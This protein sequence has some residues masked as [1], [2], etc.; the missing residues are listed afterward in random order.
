MNE[1]TLLARPRRW[2]EP[3]SPDMSDEI[4]AGLLKHPVFQEVRAEKFPSHIPLAGILKNDARV[5]PYTRG[6]I[7]VREGDYGSSAFLILKGKV[8]VVISPGLPK[9]LLGRR[10]LK[11]KNLWQSLAQLWANPR[12]IPEIRDTKKEE[13]KNYRDIGK[14]GQAR[15][16]LQDVPAILD[17]HKT[18]SLGEGELFGELAALGRIPR[19]ATV[20]AE[21][22]GVGLLEIRWQ[23]LRELR[24]YDP[25]WKRIIDERYRQN[26]LK[27]HLSETPLF[28]D[29]SPEILQ[30]VDDQTVFE[31]YGTFEWNLSREQGKNLAEEPLIVKQGDLLEGLLMVRNGFARVSIRLESGERTLTYL[32]KGDYFGLHELYDSWRDKKQVPV[33]TSLR[34]LGY[35]DIL[36]VPAK[37]L[38]AHVFPKLSPPKNRLIDFARRPV[39]EDG[40]LE[41]AGRE[42]WINATQA[43]V[44]DLEKCTRCDDCVKACADTHGGNPR[45][46][47]QGKVFDRWMVAQACMHCID[48]VCLIGCPTGAIHRVT[49]TGT[50]TINQDTCIGCG[51]CANACP[52]E[53]I[54]MVET[55]DPEG[56]P[57]LDPQSQTPIQKATQCD[58]CVDQLGGPACVRACPH[59][60]LERR[61]FLSLLK[62]RKD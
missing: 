36:R 8:R 12:R 14:S 54:Q 4:V 34:G 43:M 41:W 9:E 47:R 31:T 13:N 48:P 56:R 26:T 38:E 11:K 29:L 18:A 52:Y 23:G 55:R 39:K 24:K 5:I 61:D 28:K 33:E 59:D 42:R 3:F 6:D 7:I 30:T 60:A 19:T 40:F 62:L 20:F 21:D 16:F 58:L 44:I 2:D 45:F 25:G 17:Q 35:V 46:I 37:L 53:N 32:T 49:E 1:S 10:V 50:V 57:I 22:E 15:V 51:V 27:V